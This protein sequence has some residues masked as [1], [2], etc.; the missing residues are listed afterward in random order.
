MTERTRNMLRFV[1]YYGTGYAGIGTIILWS[2]NSQS[3]LT[4]SILTTSIS[5][6]LWLVIASAGAYAILEIIT[7][8]KQRGFIKR[9]QLLHGSNRLLHTLK[10]TALMLIV[11]MALKFGE[12]LFLSGDLITRE[13]LWDFFESVYIALGISLVMW[14]L[15]NDS[16]HLEHAL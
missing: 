8:M 16:F 5:V 14:D 13:L 2:F 7:R 6:L 10:S 12:N 9:D 15:G 3:F 4:G 1:L 11:L